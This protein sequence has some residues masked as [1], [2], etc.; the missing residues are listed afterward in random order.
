MAVSWL[1][2]EINKYVYVTMETKQAVRPI[3]RQ[4]STGD[5]GDLII[6]AIICS[7]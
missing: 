3:P 5:H 7:S 6:Y 2:G 4:E 1:L